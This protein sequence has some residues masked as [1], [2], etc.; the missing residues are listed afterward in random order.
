[1]LHDRYVPPRACALDSK[2]V[3]QFAVKPKIATHRFITGAV[4]R[5]KNR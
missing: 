1:M 4:H 3:Y 2:A 5:S